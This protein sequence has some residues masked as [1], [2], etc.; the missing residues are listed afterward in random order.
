MQRIETDK[1]FK[2]LTNM[3]MRLDPA[4]VLQCF[5]IQKRPCVFLPYGYR[6]NEFQNVVH[7]LRKSVQISSNFDTLI[8]LCNSVS[9][10]IDTK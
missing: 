7:P 8:Y 3:L 4:N 5:A 10:K 9:G 1:L 6:P 2:Y